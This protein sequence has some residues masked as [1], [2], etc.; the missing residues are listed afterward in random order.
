[1]REHEVVLNAKIRRQWDRLMRPIGSGLARMGVAPDAVTA[2][3]VVLQ[4]VAA[5]WIV[6]GRLV[7]AGFISAAA[8]LMDVLDGAVAR[9][10]GVVTKFGALLDST[11]DRLA[12]ALVFIPIAWLY[13][14]SPD[15][16]EHDRPWVAA[17]ALVAMVASFLVSYVKA[18]AEGL[19]F[20]CN[21]GFAE[22]AE[23]MILMILALLFDVVPIAV[24]LVAAASTI[25]FVQRIVHVRKQAVHAA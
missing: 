17:V 14:V 25:T 24:V 19:G 10:K 6:E 23:R 21:I 18:R 8:A 5:A 1:L 12:D 20:E 22:R 11:T 15:I 16:P 3:G 9:A 4:V 7:A 13:G 2:F